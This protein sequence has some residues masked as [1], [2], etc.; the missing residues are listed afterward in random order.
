MSRG[1]RNRER[2]DRGGPRG[3]EEDGSERGRLEEGIEG[4]SGPPQEGGRTGEGNEGE[5]GEGR[6]EREARPG[7]CVFDRGRCRE[8]RRPAARL[9]IRNPTRPH[10]TRRDGVPGESSPALRPRAGRRGEGGPLGAG[11]P[12]ENAGPPVPP[13]AE[14]PRRREGDRQGAPSLREP[15]RG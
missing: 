2:E 6:P 13:A 12:R 15:A 4:S 14:P 7:A 9:P 10:P 3:R 8:E 1:N 5:E 11:G